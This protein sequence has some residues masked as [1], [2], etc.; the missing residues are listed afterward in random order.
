[1]SQVIGQG[2]G[3]ALKQRDSPSSEKSRARVQDP[4]IFDGK[5][6]DKLRTFLF[7][8]ILNFKDHPSAF[9]RDHQKVNYMISYLTGDALG[10]FKPSIV[11]PDPENVPAWLD[12][13]DAFVSELVRLE[14]DIREG[15]ATHLLCTVPLV[16]GHRELGLP[17]FNLSRIHP[18]DSRPFHNTRI[19]VDSDF[20]PEVY[21]SNWDHSSTNRGSTGS[22]EY[23]DWELESARGTGAGTGG[24]VISSFYIAPPLVHLLQGGAQ[25]FHVDAAPTAATHKLA[26]AGVAATL[27]GYPNHPCSSEDAVGM[28]VSWGKG[29]LERQLPH[30]RPPPHPMYQLRELVRLLRGAGEEDP[31]KAE[32]EDSEKRDQE[33]REMSEA[34]IQEG[35]SAGLHRCLRHSRADAAP[36]FADCAHMLPAS[37]LRPVPIPVPT[38]DSTRAL[39][40]LFI[41]LV[42]T[43][44]FSLDFTQFPLLPILCPPC[45]STKHEPCASIARK[46]CAYI[47]LMRCQPCCPC[48]LSRGLTSVCTPYRAMAHCTLGTSARNA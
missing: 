13:Y 1:M 31:D 46:Q 27:H 45:S 14:E 23:Y 38:S 18:P 43:S 15:N 47:C 17:A 8:G 2:I 7:Q 22:S 16:Y 28:G 48:R 30:P 32:T 5:D 37:E 34:L 25:S 26:R 42:H 36:V 6:P 41:P 9:V 11:D 39:V 44:I 3:D 35:E 33:R 12:S 24:S 40:L 10:W 20:M 4:D 21:I 29:M 19:P